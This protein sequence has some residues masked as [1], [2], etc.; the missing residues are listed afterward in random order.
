MLSFLRSALRKQ[1]NVADET[2]KA[3]Y[4]LQEEQSHRGKFASTNNVGRLL[5]KTCE[6]ACETKAL[7]TGQGLLR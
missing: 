1:E 5:L 3:F 7:L 6:G 4:D 2:T